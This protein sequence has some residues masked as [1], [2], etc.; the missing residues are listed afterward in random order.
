MSFPLCADPFRNTCAGFWSNVSRTEDLLRGANGQYLMP[1]VSRK[2]DL[3][4]GW[5]GIVVYFARYGRNPFYPT[6]FRYGVINLRRKRG[7]SVNL[8]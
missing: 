6:C 1:I 5:E 3:I 7:D 8:G 4:R 2:A